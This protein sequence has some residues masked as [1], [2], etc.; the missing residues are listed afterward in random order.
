MNPVMKEMVSSKSDLSANYIVIN[1]LPTLFRSY[2]FDKVYVRGLY[3]EEAKNLSKLVDTYGADIP[4]ERLA[5]VY[6]DVIRME[7]GFSLYDLEMPDFFALQTISTL[8]TVEGFGWIPD[9]PCRQFFEGKLCDG[10]VAEKFTLE[11]L[12]FEDPEVTSLPIPIK[13]AG[14]DVNVYPLTIADLITLDRYPEGDRSYITYA[15]MLR[16]ETD[17]LQE[18]VKR[19]KF[20]SPAEGEYLSEMDKAFFIGV[21]KF[22]KRCTT[23]GQHNEVRVGLNKIKSFP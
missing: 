13:L 15:L 18:R 17:T 6:E 7:G 2:G 8:N 23:C 4:M 5:S 12:D 3:F 11:D 14:K 9:L 16:D 20:C 10:R 19:I 1:Q 22:Q 21:K